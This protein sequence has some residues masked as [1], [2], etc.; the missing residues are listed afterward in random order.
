MYK[1]QV[2]DIDENGFL[3]IANVGGILPALRVAREVVFENGVHGIISVSYTHLAFL[4]KRKFDE[5]K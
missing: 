4:K 3:R 2:V 5:V 1:R